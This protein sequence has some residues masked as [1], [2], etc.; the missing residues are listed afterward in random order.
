MN[1]IEQVACTRPPEYREI[2]LTQ[3]QVALVDAADFEWLNQYKWCALKREDGFCAVRAV[4]HGKGKQEFI[5]MHRQ[6]AGNPKGDVD[7]W[8]GNGLHNWRDNLR[9]CGHTLNC[10]NRGVGKNNTTG[11]KG[12][13]PTPNGRWS[14]HIKVNR[15]AIHLGT[16]DTREEAARLYDAK[17]LEV[18]G[19]FARLNFPEV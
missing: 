7:H 9:P 5:Y 8:D 13:R 1:L 2:K 11:F 3:N 6:I 16:R 14:A 19:K 17:A 18:W 4:R 10:A 15:I 12:I